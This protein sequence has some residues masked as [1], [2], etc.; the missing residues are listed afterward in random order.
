MASSATRSATSSTAWPGSRAGAGSSAWS[1]DKYCVDIL[2]RSRVTS[3]RPRRAEVLDGTCTAASR[4]DGRRR[5]EAEAKTAELLEA[6]ERFAD[7]L[8]HRVASQPQTFLFADLASYTALTEVHGD[9][10]AVRL[11]DD[12]CAAMRRLLPE[13]GAHEVKTIGDALLVRVPDADQAVRLGIRAAREIGGAEHGFPSVRVGMHHGPA[14]ERSGDYFGRT[15]NIAARVSALAGA[16]EVLVTDDVVRAAGE[17]ESVRFIERGR[18]PLRGDR[19]ACPDLPRLTRS[20]GVIGGACRSIPSATW[21]STP[22]ASA[23]MIVHEG[24][25]YY[26]CSLHCVRR[27]AS[28]PEQFV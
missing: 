1:K 7:A 25:R 13:H 12:Y 20:A 14:I 17:V 4:G 28:E 10:E 9:E 24:V 5:K 22:N 16:G 18:H 19:G 3:A 15:V 6:V 2:T 8:S 23:G 27:F 26:F 21:P 11:V